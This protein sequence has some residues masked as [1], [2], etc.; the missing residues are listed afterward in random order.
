MSMNCE[1]FKDKDLLIVL[2]SN[3]NDK[4]LVEH[5]IGSMNKFLSEGINQIITAGFKLEINVSAE[6]INQD[7]KPL[8]AVQG[9]VKFRNVEITSP[10]RAGERSEGMNNLYPNTARLQGRHYSSGVYVGATMNFTAY[11]TSGEQI[12]KEISVDKIKVADI[13]CMVGSEYCHTSRMTA[14]EKELHQ[15]DPRDPGAYFILGGNEWV[16]SCLE[17]KIYNSPNIYRNVGHDNEI[18]RLEFISKPGDAYEN[19]QELKMIYYLDGNIHVSIS[20]DTY[21]KHEMPI[22]V[23]FKLLGMHRHQEII[24]NVVYGYD[25]DDVVSQHMVNVMKVALT[26]KDKH[27]HS[28]MSMTDRDEITNYIA[29]KLVMLDYTSQSSAVYEVNEGKQRWIKNNIRKTLDRKLLPHVGLNEKDRHNKLRFL[30]HLLHQ[31]ILVEFGIMGSSDRDTLTNKRIHAAGISLAKTFKRAFNTSIMY[32]LKA[33]IEKNIKDIPFEEIPFTQ[34]FSA[35]DGSSLEKEIVNSITTG[36]KEIKIGNRIAKNNLASE[37]LTRKNQVHVLSALRSV[38]TANTTSA[39]T[40][41]RSK[42]MRETHSSY[43]TY[44]CP[45]QSAATGKN[46]G[47]VKQMAIGATFTNSS[48]SLLLKKQLTSDNDITHLKYCH[49]QDIYKGLTKIMVNGEWIG[50]TDKPFIVLQRYRE[51]RRGIKFTDFDTKPEKLDNHLINK[52]TTIRWSSD[53]NIIYFWVD[54][55]RAISPYIVVRNNGELDPYGRNYFGNSYDPYKNEGFVQDILITEKHINGLLKGT[56]TFDDL[57][58][59]GLVEYISAGEAENCYCAGSIQDLKENMNNPLNQYTHCIIPP[60]IFGVPV[61][62]TPFAQCNQTVRNAYNS[63]QMK[64]AQGI[65]CLNYY[66]RADKS[67][68]IQHYCHSPLTTTFS[69][70]YIFPNGANVYV[71][72][73]SY[74]GYNMEDSL[75]LNKNSSDRGLF[76]SDHKAFFYTKLENNE[77]FSVPNVS[78]IGI[79]DNANYSKLNK[80]GFVECGAILNQNDAVIGKINKDIKDDEEKLIDKSIIYKS[81][82]KGVLDFMIVAKNNNGEE[83]AKGVYSTPRKLGIGDKFSS[84]AGQKGVTGAAY[85]QEDMPFMMNGISPDLILNNAAIPAR[86]TFGQLIECM[87]NKLA[88][89]LGTSIDA[90]SF[91]NN[92]IQWYKEKLMSM[93][94]RYDGRERLFNGMTGEW[95]DASVFIGPVYY[96]RLQKYV[97]EQIYSVNIGRRDL[98]TM[99][100][101]SGKARTGGL[102]I[103]ELCKDVITSHGTGHF[104]ME[105]MRDHSDGYMMYICRT[106]GN[107]PVVNERKRMVECKNC[108]MLGLVPDVYKVPTKWSAKTFIQ[109]LSSMNIGM[110]LE[111]DPFEYEIIEENYDEI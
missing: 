48:S 64:Q 60:S 98:I 46:V 28:I 43:P 7:K 4:K 72:V 27:F 89:Q 94:L 91:C 55:G 19:S 22:Y 66:Y 45:T 56:I 107:M 15:E 24:D 75:I 93:G 14:N 31:L 86:M 18:T 57:L 63:M 2:D 30:G 96:Q 81:H 88:V 74:E 41:E 10:V 42:V 83:F 101:L 67:A 84:R 51:Y 99:Q 37:Q 100:P 108:N 102:K 87:S 32:P 16:V 13:P 26:T 8:A 106:C 29:N 12:D 52:Y 111:L 82:E 50:C 77:Y 36:N 65:S 62:S 33:N 104:L 90:S 59:E 39:N 80:D 38:K 40:G 53:N 70:N 44:I 5:H 20:G 3:I 21:L 85:N 11:T 1:K 95:M 58:L 54:P 71:A 17:S 103:S 61:N 76:Y 109:E 34:T 73:L 35:I 49:P 105:A 6:N 92:S 79:Q 68:S 9:E 110:K 69:N 97:V 23:Y 78:T 25:E 47:L